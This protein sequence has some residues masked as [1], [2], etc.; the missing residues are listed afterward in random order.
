MGDFII[1][2]GYKSVQET[3]MAPSAAGRKCHWI[4]G[5][6]TWQ[7]PEKKIIEKV[8]KPA[9]IK[10]VNGQCL[11]NKLESLGFPS[12]LIRPGYDFDKLKPLKLNKDPNV[13]ILGGLNKQGRHANSK[14][15]AW[16]F[17]TAKALKRRYGK[18]IQLWMFGMEPL[19]S[20]TVVDNF[21]RNPPIEQKNSIFNHVD[22]W[23]SPSMLEGLH[24]PPAEAMITECPVVGTNAEMAGTIDYLTHEVTGIVTNNDIFS[25]IKGVERLVND[26]P[27][28]K[29]L[30]R[31]ARTRILEIGNRRQNMETLINLFTQLQTR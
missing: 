28:R 13:V 15:T 29:K 6:E 18:K 4:R 9:T 16:V 5:W 27:L 14:R 11:Q 23:L 24:M 8:L 2:T 3:V 22:I 20:T 21:V 25:F 30:G 1:A 12:Y 7:Y 10:L 19:P 26:P 17:E 31:N